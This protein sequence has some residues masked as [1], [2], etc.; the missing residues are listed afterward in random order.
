MPIKIDNLAIA[1][2]Y[3]LLF[4]MKVNSYKIFK[5]QVIIKDQAT[6]RYDAINLNFKL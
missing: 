3:I 5:V 1:L 4:Y 2:N 6:A